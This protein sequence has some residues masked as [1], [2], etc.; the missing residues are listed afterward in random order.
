MKLRAW[1]VDS[2]TNQCSLCTIKILFWN[3][4]ITVAVLNNNTAL[5]LEVCFSNVSSWPMDFKSWQYVCMIFVCV[6]VCV[7]SLHWQLWRSSCTRRGVESL[8]G[9]LLHVPLWQRHRRSSGVQLLQH[10]D[11][12]V[13][14][15]RRGDHQP[16]R[17]QQLL[18][19][20]S[21]RWGPEGSS[22]LV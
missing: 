13:P 21:L 11:A 18:P 1:I 16:S 5:V 10:G 17:R 15:S 2:Y 9:R 7:C 6:C 19:T 4:T 22:A 20:E 8:E 14:T 12:G 3:C